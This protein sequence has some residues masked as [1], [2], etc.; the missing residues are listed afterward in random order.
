MR[1][2]GL[3]ALWPSRVATHRRDFS[4][5]SC[6]PDPRGLAAANVYPTLQLYTKPQNENFEPSIRVIII[7]SRRRCITS[8]FGYGIDEYEK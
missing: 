7:E 4:N 5:N 3:R 6:H 2:V 8:K 1:L